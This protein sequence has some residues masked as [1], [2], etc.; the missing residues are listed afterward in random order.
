VIGSIVQFD[1][2]RMRFGRTTALDGVSF[3]LETGVTGLPG[4]GV[5]LHATAGLGG[6]NIDF[7]PY[8][9]EV[10]VA[11]LDRPPDQVE[12]VLRRHWQELSS[13]ATSS[14]RAAELL[15]AH[16]SAGDPSAQARPR[17]C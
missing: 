11:L 10:A 14:A 1:A 4:Y 12:Q 13:P 6:P 17:N 7:G 8:E 16:P 9:V 2:V 5:T 3:D 15:A